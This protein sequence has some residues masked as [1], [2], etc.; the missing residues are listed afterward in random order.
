VSG[1]SVI[2]TLS[3][4]GIGKTKDGALQMSQHWSLKKVDALIEKGEARYKG[5]YKQIRRHVQNGTVKKRYFGMTK[6]AD[7]KIKV[8]LE[9]IED[10]GAKGIKIVRGQGNKSKLTSSTFAHKT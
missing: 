4:S 3:R 7:G 1:Y 10:V 9:H 6:L 2:C 5:Y 8:I